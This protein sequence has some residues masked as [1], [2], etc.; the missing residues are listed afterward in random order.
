MNVAVVGAGRVG[1]AM[2]V[3]LHRAGHRVA[4]ISGRE[5]SRERASRFLPRVA[6][7]DPVDAAR[8]G[9]LVLVA[10]PDDRIAGLVEELAA[11]GA[12]REGQWV[13]HVSGALGLDVLRPAAVT[14]AGR[15]A[16]HPLQTFPDVVGALDRIPGSAMA[17]TSD[18]DAGHRLGERIARDLRAVPFRLE[19]AK[20]PLYHA[21]A[22]FASNYLIVTAGIAEGLFRDAG[23]PDPL[24]AMLPL[25]RASI[26]NVERL[27]PAGALTGPAVRGDAMTIERNLG[28][29]EGTAPTTVPAYVE[30]CRA[31]IELA[32]RAGRLSDEGR[33]SLEDV[34]ARWS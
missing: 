29:L 9:D 22:V 11:G 33:A 20:R 24:G 7:L 26:D 21:A 14:G 28:A 4:A 30:L 27:G 15:L 34:L 32:A 25:L 17:V 12:L 10:V 23:V 1:T 13:A 16:I 3:L 8:A 31:A 19:D 5:A 6:L 18:D 2:A